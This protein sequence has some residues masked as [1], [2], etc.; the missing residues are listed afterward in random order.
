MAWR[1]LVL[2]A[3]LLPFAAARAETPRPTVI[4]IDSSGSMSAAIGGVPRLDAARGVLGEM[5]ARWPGAAPVGLVAYGHRRS[6]D[7]GDIEVLSPIGPP[8][9]AALGRRLATLRARGKTPLAASL[10]QAAGMLRA[11]GGG[12]TIILV[13]DGIETCH[14]DPCAVAAALRAADAALSVHVIGFAVEAKDE[15]QLS[16]I[17][18]AGGGAYRTAADADSL[19]ATLDSAARAATAPEPAPARAEPPP[20]EASAPPVEAPAPVEVPEPVKAA[21]VSVVAVIPGE[22]P[23]SD[24]AI[25][26]RVAGGEGPEPFRYEGRTSLVELTV[27]AG[28]YA[29]EAAVGNVA[30][31]RDVELSGEAARIEVPLAAGRLKAQAVPYKGAEP[32]GEGLRWTL[33]P[34]DG[35]AAVEVPAVARP[36][37]LLAAGRYRLAVEHQGRRS[38]Q[39]VTVAAGHPLDLALSLRLGELKLSAALAEDGEPLTDWRGLAWRALAPDGTTAAEAVQEAAPLFVLPTGRYRVELAVAG[40]AVLRDVEIEEGAQREAR[41][42][43]PT[44]SRILAAALGPGAEPLTD[45]RDTSWTV[46]AVDAIGIAQGTALMQDQPIANPT[47]PLL[48]G[49]WHIAVKSGVATA[50]RDIVVAPDTEETVRLDLQAGR[51]GV[52]ASP[53]EGAAAPMNI[54]F[55]FHPVAADGSPGPAAFAGG[56]SRSLE[57]ILPAGRWHVS[58][59][60]D[61]SRR[62]EAMV[63]LA[64]GDEKLLEMTLTQGK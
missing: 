5:L 25:D 44:G 55:E 30:A 6:G 19:L 32:I 33:T 39:E 45:W 13:T 50:E 42:V 61:D 37:L 43:V 20:A 3:S 48:P 31:H 2:L 15:Q 7:C 21:R 64:A 59:V 12:G 10:Q 22:G 29:I 16:C 63:D 49:R 24:L 41:I 56:S 23:V 51:L 11:A 8:D 47:V 14:P 62:A 35:Q 58:A 57:A 60:A 28:R 34:L 46:T 52:S 36:A 18:S 53:E 4:V 54:V 26:W 1:S 27:P 17:A 40:T 9:T 38:D